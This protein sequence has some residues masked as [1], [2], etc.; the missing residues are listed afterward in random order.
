M[1]KLL[2]KK[3]PSLNTQGG[4]GPTCKKFAPKRISQNKNNFLFLFT[5]L[6]SHFIYFWQGKTLVTSWGRGDAEGLVLG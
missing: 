5:S 1:K 3:G 4:E 6:P 2:D